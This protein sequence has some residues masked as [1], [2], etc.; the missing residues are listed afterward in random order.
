MKRFNE[1]DFVS[2]EEGKYFGFIIKHTKLSNGIN[3][4]TILSLENLLRKTICHVEECV[5]SEDT[6]TKDFSK[7]EL[8]TFIQEHLP[9]DDFKLEVLNEMCLE[10]LISYISKNIIPQKSQQPIGRYAI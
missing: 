5:I 6:S 1:G 8:L 3:I 7:E 4:Y 2:F 9:L 10:D